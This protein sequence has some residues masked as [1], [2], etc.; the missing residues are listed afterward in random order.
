MPIATAA[1]YTPGDMTTDVLAAAGTILPYV[2]AGVGGAVLLL[3]VFLGIRAG[4]RW[5]MYV[6][7]DSRGVDMV[8]FY[9]EQGA[10][11]RAAWDSLGK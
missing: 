11:D 10:R 4:F 2:G 3:F 1:G 6:T 5:F 9:N 7:G 8:A